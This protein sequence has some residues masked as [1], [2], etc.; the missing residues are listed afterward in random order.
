[1]PNKIANYIIES[2]NELKNVAWPTKKEV[3]YHTLLVIGISL[4]V[5]LFLGAVD[6]VLNAVLDKVI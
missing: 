3:K 6:Y 1:M 4:G 2:K 5:A